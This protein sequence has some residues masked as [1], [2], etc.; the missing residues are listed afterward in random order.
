LEI[1]QASGGGAASSLDEA[2]GR[3]A[4]S[5]SGQSNINIVDGYEWM[6][7]EAGQSGPTNSIVHT[8]DSPF[9]K[10]AA[11]QLI[12]A[13]MRANK[14]RITDVALLDSLHEIALDQAI[15]T[16]FSSMIVLVNQAQKDRLEE[17]ENREDRFQREVEEIGDTQA[18]GPT[19]T[20]VPE[21]EEWLLIIL[22]SGMLLWYL[23]KQRQRP[24]HGFTPV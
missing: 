10:M 4:V 17:L 14:G 12:L 1:I 22:A 18:P 15:V 24:Q 7:L 5:L 20:G 3:L 6:V 2:F 21:P 13:D 8:S 23:W 11:R 19:V 16:P 9:A